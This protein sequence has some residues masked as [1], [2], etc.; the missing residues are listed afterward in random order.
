MELAYVPAP[1]SEALFGWASCENAAGLHRSNRPTSLN[2][3][4]GPAPFRHRALTNV[5]WS[6][7][8]HDPT[9]PNNK[10]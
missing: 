7:A 5:Q 3:R 9:V 4:I 6:Q 1:R 2:Q 10:R 8:S